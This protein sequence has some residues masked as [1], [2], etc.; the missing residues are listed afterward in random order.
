MLRIEVPMLRAY[1]GPL[2]FII[3]EISTAPARAVLNLVMRARDYCLD[4]KLVN[5]F[6]AATRQWEPADVPLQLLKECM[7]PNTVSPKADRVGVW[8]P[9]SRA[10]ERPRGRV[11]EEGGTICALLKPV[12]PTAKDWYLATIDLQRR[13][14]ACDCPAYTGED[15]GVKERGEEW[16]KR[17]VLCKHLLLTAFELS[18]RILDASPLPPDQKAQWR[19]SKAKIFQQHRNQLAAGAGGYAAGD[20]VTKVLAANY[21]YFF[22]K[23]VLPKMEMRPANYD[24]DSL[25]RVKEE[26]AG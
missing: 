25:R 2:L 8:D 9:I 22:V 6:F 17:H 26:L 20:R 12:T 16:R 21:L 4:E 14:F 13:M 11:V 3:E 19:E 1:T 10:L 23:H 18:D 7:P 15:R 5:W 24:Q